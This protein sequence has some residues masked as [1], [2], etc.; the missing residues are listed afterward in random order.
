M[1]EPAARKICPDC[2][3]SSTESKH[4][5]AAATRDSLQ[6]FGICFHTAAA[7]ASFIPNIPKPLHFPLNSLF[8][9]LKKT[10]YDFILFCQ[11]T[12]G[13]GLNYESIRGDG[14]VA[15]ARKI[16][17]NVFFSTQVLEA[18][19]ESAYSS[20]WDTNSSAPST[21]TLISPLDI[22]PAALAV[23]GKA[24]TFPEMFGQS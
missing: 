7:A 16:N 5:E 2:S 21:D 18:D 19:Q 9:A 24:L 6:D 14:N 10:C 8:L 17:R 13:H 23:L 12:N 22:A 15:A 1:L 3:C 11:Q 4:C 20:L